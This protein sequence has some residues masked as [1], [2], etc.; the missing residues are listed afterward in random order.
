M[1][2]LEDMSAIQK[3]KPGQTGGIRRATAPTAGGTHGPA[4]LQRLVGNRAVVKGLAGG[5]TAPQLGIIRRRGGQTVKAPLPSRRDFEAKVGKASFWS[6]SYKAVLQGLQ[7]YEKIKPAD[8]P[9]ATKLI[10]RIRLAGIVYLRGHESTGKDD[11]NNARIRA[12]EDL[13]YRDLIKAETQMTGRTDLKAVEKASGGLVSE[14]QKVVGDKGEEGYFKTDEGGESSADV[15]SFFEVSRFGA[16]REV[17]VAAVDEL[18]KTGLVPKTEFAMLG[19][20]F[21]SVQKA[22]KGV[23]AQ[24][25]ETVGGRP[26]AFVVSSDLFQTS[27]FAKQL[28]TLQFLDTITGHGDRHPGNYMVWREPNGEVGLAG[29]DN[30]ISFGRASYEKGAKGNYA[31]HF[32]GLPTYL[33][34]GVVENA[35]K[36]TPAMLRS[37]LVK[38]LPPKEVELTAGRWEQTRAQLVKMQAQGRIIA[39]KDTLRWMQV[40]AQ[41]GTPGQDTVSSSYLEAKKGAEEGNAMDDSLLQDRPKYKRVMGY[42]HVMKRCLDTRLEAEG[43]EDLLKEAGEAYH[44]LLREYPRARSWRTVVQGF[45]AIR[46]PVYKERYGER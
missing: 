31:G 18:F 1:K 46:L 22:A 13:V 10:Q 38:L 29:I 12:L 11:A 8:I 40:Q 36:V 4:D 35:L 6:N 14:V 3:A 42:L 43:G 15:A 34:E 21:G 30:D 9:A 37:V 25:M 17:A 5:A 2:S 19:D 33:D 45:E 24:V 7:D 28:N 27:G 41:A 20:K 44:Q 23:A 26:A 39:K 16:N 32:K